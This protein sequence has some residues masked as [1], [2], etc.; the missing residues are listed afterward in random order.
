MI[1][2]VFPVLALSRVL[3]GK[4]KQAKDSGTRKIFLVT[5]GDYDDYEIVGAFST[6]EKAEDY[7]GEP[8]LDA[9]R[10]Q[11]ENVM[12]IGDRGTWFHDYSKWEYY[13]IEEVDL[14]VL[15]S[16]QWKAWRSTTHSEIGNRG[17]LVFTGTTK[18]MATHEDAVELQ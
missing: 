1:C 18:G 5:R 15:S 7:L 11:H 6:R 4:A 16:I 13:R 10:S 14:D 8:Q 12:P 17:E 2:A 9:I 3:K